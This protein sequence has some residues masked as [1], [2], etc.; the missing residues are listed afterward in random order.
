[1]KFLNMLILTLAIVGCLNWGLIGLFN[2]NLVESLFG[3]FSWLTTLI[4]IL[5]GI[6]GIYSIAFYNKVNEEEHDR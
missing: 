6:A 1:M 3:S 4:Y 2:F 5:V